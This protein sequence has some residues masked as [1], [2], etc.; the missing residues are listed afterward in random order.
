MRLE[1]FFH[2]SAHALTAYA[3]YSPALRALTISV[4]F[5]EL[6]FESYIRQRPDLLPSFP[7]VL[8]EGVRRKLWDLDVDRATW[9]DVVVI[10]WQRLVLQPATSSTN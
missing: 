5:A 9:T 8:N 7:W 1:L 6:V 10:R 2:T 4:P 3:T